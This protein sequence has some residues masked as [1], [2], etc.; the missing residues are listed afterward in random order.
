MEI[1]SYITALS[2]FSLIGALISYLI[3]QGSSKRSF[4]FI[5]SVVF[6]YIIIS[7]L[8]NSDMHDLTFDFVVLIFLNGG[9]IYL[10]YKSSPKSNI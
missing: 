10:V 7:P 9:S 3:P 1:K 5:S 8:I 4:R 6:V 2:L